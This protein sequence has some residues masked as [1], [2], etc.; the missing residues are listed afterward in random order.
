MLFPFLHSN[1]D[2]LWDLRICQNILLLTHSHWS[3][4]SF[5]KKKKINKQNLLVVTQ[6]R[7]LADLSHTFKG[8]TICCTFETLR[9]PNTQ[10][11]SARGSMNQVV[12]K[13]TVLLGPAFA[14]TAITHFF[15]F[16]IFLKY[17]SSPVLEGV[18][19]NILVYWLSIWINIWAELWNWNPYF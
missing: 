8:Q 1:F 5:W 9:L 17:S 11:F 6:F 18:A 15:L 12:S 14:L 10:H 4:F 7:H 13:G 2:N 3:R 16:T 19:V